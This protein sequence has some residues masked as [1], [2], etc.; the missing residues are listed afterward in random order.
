MRENGGTG[1]TRAAKVLR[2]K[3]CGTFFTPYLDLVATARGGVSPTHAEVHILRR[4]RLFVSELVSE[5]G[6]GSG[7]VNA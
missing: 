1:M 6:R 3:T 5:C 7:Q 4:H 2:R